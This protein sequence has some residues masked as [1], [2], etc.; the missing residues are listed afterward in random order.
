MR[1][2]EIDGKQYTRVELH[3]ESRTRLYNIWKGIKDRCNNSNCKAFN[4]YGGRGIEVCSEWLV[5]FVAFRGWALSNGYKEDLTIERKDVNGNYDPS[6][7]EWIPSIEQPKNR[8]NSIYIDG[9][10]LVEFCKINSV[11]YGLVNRRYKAGERDPERL[12]RPPEP[13]PAGILKYRESI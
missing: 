1:F 6:N 10:S 5:S 13:V 3:G 11:K 9:M 12:C 2:V 4:D 7:C 8:R